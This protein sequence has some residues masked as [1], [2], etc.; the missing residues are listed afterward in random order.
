MPCSFVVD[1]LKSDWYKQKLSIATGSIALYYRHHQV[2]D[3]RA[4]SYYSFWAKVWPVQN[5]LLNCF[6][7]HN[8]RTLKFVMIWWDLGKE[9]QADIPTSQGFSANYLKLAALWWSLIIALHKHRHQSSHPLYRAWKTQVE[10]ICHYQ[11]ISY[12]IIWLK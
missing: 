11:S 3:Q 4:P 6:C 10:D 2:L 12:E 7:H 8:S 1:R 9:K 5:L